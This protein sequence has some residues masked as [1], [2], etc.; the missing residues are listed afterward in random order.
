MKSPKKEQGCVLALLSCC[1]VD[2]GNYFLPFNTVIVT[3]AADE[4]GLSG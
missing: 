3:V 4:S 2:E 1:R